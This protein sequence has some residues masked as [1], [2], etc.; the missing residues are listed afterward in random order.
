[1]FMSVQNQKEIFVQ[2]LSGLRQG[3][4][5]STKFYQELSQIA[6][7]PDIKEALEARVFVSEKVLD[8]QDQCFKL[9]GEQ[10]TKVFVPILVA[11]FSYALI[12]PSAIL[13]RMGA[14]GWH[15]IWNDPA[16]GFF[17]VTVF[18]F[19]VAVFSCVVDT[20]LLRN[21]V[22]H[23]SRLNVAPILYLIMLIVL[24][25]G[26]YLDFYDIHRFRQ[27]YLVSDHSKMLELAS[28]HD[29]VF[30]TKDFPSGRML[31]D[32]GL[33]N[34]PLSR[35]MSRLY[36]VSNFVNVVFGVS[37]FCYLFLLTLKPE[38][39]GERTCNHL[40][41]VIS[42]LA[43]WFP[44]RAYADWYMNLSNVSW[45]GTYQAAW[46]LLV[47]LVVACIIPSTAT[48]RFST[49]TIMSKSKNATVRI[50]IRR[51]VQSF[52]LEVTPTSC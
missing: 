22:S 24:I 40:V 36:M 47:L 12:I 46:I 27:P 18:P 49:L 23:I 34:V 26:V 45:I 8:T 7:D 50:V 20:E 17:M 31:Y 6:E 13:V 44:C 14:A 37:V 38:R 19:S 29:H 3:T 28:L 5:R 11:V 21:S 35:L 15:W 43:V 51:P 4:E 9:I 48:G 10:P 52:A 1:M 39:V 41:F 30:E 2:L 16:F 33:H 32:N 25:R 42:T